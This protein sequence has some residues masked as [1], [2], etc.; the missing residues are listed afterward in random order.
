MVLEIL[1]SIIHNGRKKCNTQKSNYFGGE[2]NRLMSQR[3]PTGAE[4]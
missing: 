4:M 2:K 1:A 3:C